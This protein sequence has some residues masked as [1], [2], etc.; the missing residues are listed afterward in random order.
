M[1]AALAALLLLAAPAAAQDAPRVALRV[2]SHA[3]HGRLVFDWPARVAY[4]AESQDS[5]TL[6]RFDAPGRIDLAAAR[7]PPRNVIAV[8]Q[9]GDAVLVRVAPGARLRHF[10]LGDR[11]VVDVLDAP[12]AVAEPRA[13]SAPRAPTL[14]RQSKATTAPDAQGALAADAVPASAPAMPVAVSAV[15]ASTPGMP[16]ALSAVPASAPAAPA[17]AS[18]APASTPAPPASAPTVRTSAPAA[19]ASATTGPVVPPDRIEDPSQRLCTA[20][21]VANDP[22]P[23]DRFFVGLLTG[24]GCAAGDVL[25]FSFAGAGQAAV[26][27]ARHCRFD[28]PVLLDRGEQ[29]HLV[30]IWLGTMRSVR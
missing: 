3:D 26:V 27:A 11:I 6:L 29:T 19:P 10:R 4:T 20:R 13:A 2:G 28:A 23:L 7:R 5:R 18:A 1:R 14:P 25:H 22:L 30:C 17:S 21:F 12:A 8:E 16:V 9:A 24:D 15:P